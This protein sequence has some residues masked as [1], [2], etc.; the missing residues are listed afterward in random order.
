MVPRISFKAVQHKAEVWFFHARQ[1]PSS[2]R[3][4]TDQGA[5]VQLAR[6]QNNGTGA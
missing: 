4:A 6:R 1:C 3:V 2:F 5:W